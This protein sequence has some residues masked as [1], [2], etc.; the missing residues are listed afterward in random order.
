MN[1]EEAAAKALAFREERD[2][3]QF[4][5]PKD[6]AISICLEAS[7]L[8]ELF[9]WSASDCEVLDKRPEMLEE[10]ADVMIYCIHLA[11]RLNADIP[12]IIQ[13]KMTKNAAKYPAELARG[14]SK[15]YDQI[16]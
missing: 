14:S 9:Q 12:A 8:L 4:H 6:L 10:L 7:E 2:W 11:D 5:N 16:G 13:D 1:F 3:S 15:K